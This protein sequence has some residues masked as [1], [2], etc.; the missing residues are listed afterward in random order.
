MPIPKGPM[1]KG[2]ADAEGRQPAPLEHLQPDDDAAG[3]FVVQATLVAVIDNR[4]DDEQ[5]QRGADDDRPRMHP[6]SVEA[7][8][9][10]CRSRRMPIVRPIRLTS[11]RYSA[12]KTTVIQGE[13]LPG[14]ERAGGP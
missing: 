3:R 13:L 8:S 6:A 2:A 5:Q 9:R 12:A 11:T 4:R 1:P 7:A 10:R 14:R